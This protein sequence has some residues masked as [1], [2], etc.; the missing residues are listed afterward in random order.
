MT[1]LEQAEK[2]LL[3]FRRWMEEGHPWVPGTDF[4]NNPGL[5]L[6]IQAALV[7][8]VHDRQTTEQSQ[9]D[10]RPSSVA[11]ER[12][13][14]RRHLSRKEANMIIDEWHGVHSGQNDDQ[15]QARPG[16]TSLLSKLPNWIWPSNW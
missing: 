5:D 10:R 14:R 6:Y 7:A 11:P 13:S 12:L 9:P 15:G 3:S 8:Y 2:T 4:I 16:R 1:P